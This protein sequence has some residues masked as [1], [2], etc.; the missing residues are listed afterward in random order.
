MSLLCAALLALSGAAPV[1]AADAGPRRLAYVAVPD[2]RATLSHVEAAAASVAPG[3]LPPGALAIGLGAQLGDPGL[4]GLGSGPLVVLL[5]GGATPVSPPAVTVFVPASNPEPYEKALT[6][7]KWKV[8]R[9]EGMVVASAEGTPILDD[10]YG[11]IA[12]DAGAADLRVALDVDAIMESYGPAISAAVDTMAA[13]MAARAPAGKEPPTT[14]M[15]P[16]SVGKILQLEFKVL[17]LLLEQTGSMVTDVTVQPEAIVTDAVVT[18]HPGSALA[19]LAAQPPAGP[20]RA[21]AL[22]SRPAVMTVTYQLD[23]ARV[24]DF[25][26]DLSRRAGSDPQMAALASPELLPLLDQSQRTFTGEAAMGMR[27]GAGAPLVAETVARVRDEASALALMEKSAAL[28]APGSLWY[29]LYADLGM[30]LRTSLQKNVRRHAGVPVHVF[31]MSLDAKDLAAEQKAQYAMF[32]RDTEFAVAR[33]YFLSAQDRAAL[34]ALIDRAAAPPATAPSLLA[35]RAFGPG[36]HAYVD[37][38]VFGLLRAVSAYLPAAPGTPHPFAAL[39]PMDADPFVYAAS[40]ADNRIRLQS[41]LPLKPFA[42]LA[43]A[44]KT[45]P[46]NPPR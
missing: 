41:K 40:L 32:M 43:E 36:A 4:A 20:N 38:D 34:N 21:A 19:A 45:H 9:R 25:V 3:M 27:A 10:E 39:P 22:L 2:L 16:A 11:R 7:R 1:S 46:P 18:A 35:E 24:A 28:L 23:S 13:G 15:P 17:Q 42:A 37:Y 5:T 6:A 29:R 44:F 33:G 26:A 31:K 30:P 14:P 12:A 8:R